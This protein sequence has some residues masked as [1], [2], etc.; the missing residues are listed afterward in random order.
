M[1]GLLVNNMERGVYNSENIFHKRLTD[2]SP[3]FRRI[4]QDNAKDKHSTTNTLR[5]KLSILKANYVS[6][7]NASPDV[8]AAEVST[9]GSHKRNKSSPQKPKKYASPLKQIDEKEV[10][11]FYFETL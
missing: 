10:L 9:N 8:T 3:V 11:Y 6:S 2:N 1:K 4:A 5:K 7:S